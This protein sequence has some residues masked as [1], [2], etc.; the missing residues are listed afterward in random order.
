M[1]N[2]GLLPRLA[3]AAQAATSEARSGPPDGADARHRSDGTRR[4][5]VPEY[6]DR[7]LRVTAAC[8]DCAA[9]AVDRREVVEHRPCGSVRP[10]DAVQAD[11]GYRCPDCDATGPAASPGFSVVGELYDCE[12][13]LARFDD[14]DYVVDVVAPVPAERTSGPS[15]P[16]QRRT[17]ARGER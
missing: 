6:P 11:G 16:R 15:S 5:P 8:P 13:C 1:V 17:L 12:A 3:T 7:E 9:T 4:Y 2:W 14:P 10:R